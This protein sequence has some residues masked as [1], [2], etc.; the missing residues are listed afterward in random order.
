M[1]LRLGSIWK[2]NPPLSVGT[3]MRRIAGSSNGRIDASE[4][5]HERSNRSPAAIV[6]T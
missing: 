1:L 6:K 3:P 4:A 2:S 5:S